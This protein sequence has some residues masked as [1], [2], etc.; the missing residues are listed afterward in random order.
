MEAITAFTTIV[1]GALAGFF[2]SLY[3]WLNQK[4]LQLP[5][6]TIYQ[7]N[8]RNYEKVNFT[9]QNDGYSDAENVVVRF[10]EH[11][12]ENFSYIKFGDSVNTETLVVFEIP[13]DSDYKQLCILNYQD[14][15]RNTYQHGWIIIKGRGKDNYPEIVRDDFYPK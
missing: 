5:R 9:I 8:V 3:F 2:A 4:K 11:N 13:K 15:W 6:L 14:V 1:A 12:M 7:G 10:D